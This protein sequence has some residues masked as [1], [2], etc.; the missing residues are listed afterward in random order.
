MTPVMKPTDVPGYWEAVEREQVARDT[1]FLCV[2]RQIHGF[3]VRP[4]TLR[5]YGELRL[6]SSPFLPPFRTPE[7]ED[8]VLFL[9]RCSP[10]FTRQRT[11]MAWRRFKK[12]CQ[13]FMPPV[14]PLFKT[15]KA[16]RKFDERSFDALVILAKLTTDLRKFVED[17]MLDKPQGGGTSGMPDFCSDLASIVD[18]LAGNYG[19]KEE[20]ILDLP[21]ARVFQYVKCCRV[22][23]YIQN[24]RGGL[25]D[26]FPVMLN[27]SDKVIADY[28]ADLNKEK[29]N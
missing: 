6:A 23:D 29:R 17:Q 27:Q 2:S 10:D 14:E 18:R 22:T 19:W 4:V 1:A 13:A 24:V 21:L 26:N 20:D 12:Q 7:A 9:W 3:T 8:V 11:G 28:M 16:M 25:K 5:S 15:A